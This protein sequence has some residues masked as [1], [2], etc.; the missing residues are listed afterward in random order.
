MKL[1]SALAISLSALIMAIAVFLGNLGHSE[2]QSQMKKRKAARIAE[3]VVAEIE[4]V[5]NILTGTGEE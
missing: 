4:T 5:D 3:S 1:H 2:F